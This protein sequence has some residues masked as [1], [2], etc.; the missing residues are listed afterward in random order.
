MNLRLQ[1]IKMALRAL[2]DNAARSALTT[3]GIIVGT[4]IVIIVLS[5]GSGVRELILRQLTTITPETLWVEVQVPSEGTRAQKDRNNGES[6]ATGVQIKTLKRRDV[7]SLRQVRNVQNAYGLSFGQE[8]FVSGNAEAT[9][10]YWAVEPAYAEMEGLKIGEGRFFT[11]SEDQGLA[12]VVVLGSD[13]KESL[14]GNRS[15][16][17]EKVKIKQQSF[18]V[19]GVA[20]PVGMKFFMNADEL[21][22]LPLGTAQKKVLGYDHLNAIAVKMTDKRLLA[23]TLTGA[24]RT[25][26]KNH[27]ITDPDKDDFVVRTMDEAMD[28]IDTVTG[29]ISLLLFALASISLIVGG[30]GIMNVMFVSVSERTQEIGLKKAI[31]A[32]PFAIRFQFLTEAAIICAMG[33]LMGIA[34][35]AGISWLVSFVAGY[36]DFDWPFILP[37]DSI[38]IAFG[39]STALGLIFGYAPANRAAKMNPIEALRS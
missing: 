20:A 17:G 38:V 36:F 8:K 31:G 5:V 23:Q 39:I 12:Q 4:A 2:T 37:L 16:I 11:T 9:A 14:F 26:R 28:I 33:G 19:I 32:A 34:L 1:I 24:N 27:G 6:V 15:A 25:L 13:L 7:E 21:A 10:M 3:L 22:Y 18:K 35:G 29:G 30:V